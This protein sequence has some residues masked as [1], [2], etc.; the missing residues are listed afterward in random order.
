MLFRGLCTGLCF[1]L[2]SSTPSEDEGVTREMRENLLQTRAAPTRS[3]V[4]LT[5]RGTSK[6]FSDSLSQRVGTGHRAR[7]VPAACQR[8]SAEAG[9]KKGDGGWG[10]LYGQ[11]PGRQKQGLYT[12]SHRK[13]SRTVQFSCKSIH[14]T[15]FHY[16]SAEN[17]MNDRQDGGVRHQVTFTFLRTNTPTAP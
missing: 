10:L 7:D 2:G 1:S 15:Y 17:V 6:T 13:M 14:L 12:A 4:T 8:R 5:L 11:I 3:S 16:L 9:G